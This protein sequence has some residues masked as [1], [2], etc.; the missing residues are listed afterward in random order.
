MELEEYGYIGVFLI[1]MFTNATI[2]IP[3]PGWVVV[4][5]LAAILNPWLIGLL[6][7][8]GAV[9]GQTTGYLLGYSG[10][11]VLKKSDRHQRII[12][13]MKRWGVLVIFL[14]ALIPNPFVD[15]VGAAAGILRYPF[16]KFIFFCILGTIPKYIFFAVAGGWGLKFFL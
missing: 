8:L 9:L 12:N 16:L 5:S 14:S 15:I 6:A 10:R 4:I 3:L 11:I 13:W 2:V 7:G 1:S